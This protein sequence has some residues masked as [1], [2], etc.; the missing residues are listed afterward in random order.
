MYLPT[1]SPLS[2]STP[3]GFKIKVRYIVYATPDKVFDALTQEAQIGEWCENGG[4]IEPHSGG[5]V[6]LFGTWIT[7]SV[8]QFNKKKKQLSYTWKPSEWD[9]KTKPSVVEFTF[10][11]HA[12]GTEL[13]IDHSELPTQKEA[14]EHEKGWVDYV[15]DPLNDYFTH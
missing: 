15:L 3:R 2:V 12:A 6:N 9:V 14:A 5:K 7:G 11:P 10:Q 8:I 13:T 1:D 4:F